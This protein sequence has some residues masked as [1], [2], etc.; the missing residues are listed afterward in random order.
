M[1]AE[2]GAQRT[3]KVEGKEISTHVREEGVESGTRRQTRGE[4][5]L[6]AYR[7]GTNEK[8]WMRIGGSNRE[9]VRNETVVEENV[10]A[11]RTCRKGGGSSE[12]T[13]RK[14]AWR[15]KVSMQDGV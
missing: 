12:T 4:V 8:G 15:D 7:D 6:N 9:R 13:I 10:S 1:V 3:T 2:S 5:S 11:T 14:G